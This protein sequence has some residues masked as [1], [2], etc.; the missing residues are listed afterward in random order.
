[1][2]RILVSVSDVGGSRGAELGDAVPACHRATAWACSPCRRSGSG[3]WVAFVRGDS[4]YPVWM[5][6]YYANG[7][8]PSLSHNVPPGISGITL[9]TAGN[10]GSSSLMHR[11]AAS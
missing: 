2:S 6:G 10:N 4:D 7:E 1:M 11:A 8:A 9:Q 3:V 5:G